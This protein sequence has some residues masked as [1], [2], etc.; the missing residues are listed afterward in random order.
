MSMRRLVVT[1]LGPLWIAALSVSATARA[2]EP[3]SLEISEGID[4]PKLARRLGTRIELTPA[5]GP[6]ET[7]APADADGAR[8]ASAAVSPLVSPATGDLGLAPAGE[9]QAGPPARPEQPRYTPRLKLGFRHFTFAQIG[10]KA[11]GQPGP[12]EPFDVLSLDLY[13]V[14]SAWRF[15]LTTQYGWEGGTFRQGGDAFIA[16]SVSLG[17][18]IPGQVF[19]PFFE[20]YAGGGLLQRTHKE[21][22]LNAAA[23]AYGQ[24]GI[25]V[26]SEIFLGRYFCVSGALGFIHAGNAFAKSNAFGSFSVDTLSFKLGIGI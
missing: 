13:P 15:G 5:A 10:A 9:V 20:A 7:G 19:T 6:A 26:G 3:G 8:G 16:Q 17:G 22:M 12:D 11:T 25:D 18:Q 23:T 21:L 4:D 1:V 2:Q 24:I 14:S